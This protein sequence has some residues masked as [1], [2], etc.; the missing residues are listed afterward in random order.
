[1]ILILYIAD[2]FDNFHSFFF[3][4]INDLILWNLSLWAV[5]TSFGRLDLDEF[6]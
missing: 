3:Q 5:Y 6:I 4:L 2:E 1:M